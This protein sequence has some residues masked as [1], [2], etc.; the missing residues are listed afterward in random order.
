MYEK[1]YRL[2]WL[3]K[4]GN[5]PTRDN[6]SPYKQALSTDFRSDLL[7]NFHRYGIKQIDNI[8]P[9]SAL[10]YLTLDYKMT[11]HNIQNFVVKT[12]RLPLEF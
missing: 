8:F 10:L 7:P 3:G 1:F 12:T 6:S 2:G 4:E 9:R 5:P 11:L